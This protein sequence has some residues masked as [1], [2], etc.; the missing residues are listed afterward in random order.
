MYCVDRSLCSIKVTHRT[1]GQR[2]P[3]APPSWSSGNKDTV[4]HPLRDS[5]S[6]CSP[7]AWRTGCA[8][9]VLPYLRIVQWIRRLLFVNVKVPVIRLHFERFRKICRTVTNEM[10]HW[11]SESDRPPVH[12]LTP[13]AVKLFFVEEMMIS[14]RSLSEGNGNP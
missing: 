5:G 12:R 2:P 1:C 3:P 6:H 11:V 9:N 4:L 14:Y 13:L 10:E 8:Q 7:P